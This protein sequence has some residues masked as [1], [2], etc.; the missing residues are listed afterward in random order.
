MFKDTLVELENEDLFFPYLCPLQKPS[1]TENY[2]SYKFGDGC[3]TC[4]SLIPCGSFWSETT[5]ITGKQM[6]YFDEI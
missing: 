2:Y 6:S 4:S 3:F 5:N 1:I